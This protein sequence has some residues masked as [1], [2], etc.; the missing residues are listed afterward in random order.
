MEQK[1]ERQGRAYAG[2]CDPEPQG[3]ARDPAQAVRHQKGKLKDPLSVLDVPS[4]RGFCCLYH[5]LPPAKSGSIGQY[6]AVFDQCQTKNPRS[7]EFS[8][9]LR[10]YSL[11][12]GRGLEPPRI[13]HT[14][15]KRARLPV[16]PPSHILFVLSIQLLR[17]EAVLADCL[18]ILP[19]SCRIVKLF[20]PFLKKIRRKHRYSGCMRGRSPENSCPEKTH[21]LKCIGTCDIISTTMEKQRCG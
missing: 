9:Q 11:V 19:R 17:F 1:T 4:E 21:K 5:V 3:L 6:L 8:T 2:N 7:Y 12:R 20:F 10:G 14:H 18:N 15:L 13:N 16:P